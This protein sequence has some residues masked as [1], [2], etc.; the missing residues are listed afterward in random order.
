MQTNEK[1]DRHPNSNPSPIPTVHGWTVPWRRNPECETLEPALERIHERR[2]VL[3]EALADIAETVV[4][5]PHLADWMLGLNNDLG[6]VFGDVFQALVPASQPGRGKQRQNGK[7]GTS[8]AGGRNGGDATPVLGMKPDAGEPQTPN[9][10]AQFERAPFELILAFDDDHM[11]NAALVRR[12]RE[13]FLATL[14]VR[15]GKPQL[16]RVT[17]AQSVRWFARTNLECTGYST[18]S[19]RAFGAWLCSAV[20]TREPAKARRKQTA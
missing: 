9:P 17:L 13:H 18:G 20:A 3:Q 12:G 8:K 1:Q 5:N 15:G 16:R 11:R 2:A 19:N 14:K 10:W 4:Q 6:R 7:E